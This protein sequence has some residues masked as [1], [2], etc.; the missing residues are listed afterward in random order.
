[1]DLS[2]YATVSCAIVATGGLD[3]RGPCE[4]SSDG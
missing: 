1:M 2:W 3:V 4:V